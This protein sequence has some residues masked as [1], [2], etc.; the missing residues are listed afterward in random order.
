MG[1]HVAVFKQVDGSARDQSAKRI[2]DLAMQ[3]LRLLRTKRRRTAANDES[4]Y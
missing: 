2:A 3:T 4:K 1:D